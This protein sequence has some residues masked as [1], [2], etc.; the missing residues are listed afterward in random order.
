MEFFNEGAVLSVAL[1]TFGFTPLLDSA[2]DRNSVG[3]LVTTI[4]LINF[5]G[6]ALVMIHAMGEEF[7]KFCRSINRGSPKGREYRKV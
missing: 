3:W 7:K 2:E 5:F 6:T 4:V 1:L